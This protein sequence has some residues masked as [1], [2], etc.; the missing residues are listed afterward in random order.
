MGG[1]GKGV[2]YLYITL[3]QISSVEKICGCLQQSP[4]RIGGLVGPTKFYP[5]HISKG[6]IAMKKEVYE[7]G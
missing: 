7:I 4:E 3:V 2:V 1:E 5:V 6:G